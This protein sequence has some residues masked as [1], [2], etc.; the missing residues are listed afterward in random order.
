MF[1]LETKDPQQVKTEEFKQQSRALVERGRGL[2]D[3]WKDKTE[4]N[5]F[6]DAGD[7][8]LENLKNDDLLC[9]L[10]EQAGIF[11]E[12][13]TYMD[14]DG[15]RQIDLEVLS[16]IRKLVVPVLADAFKYIPVPRIEESNEY[17]DYVIENLTICAYDIIPENIR[18]RLES[19]Y[20]FNTKE[21]ETEHAYTK[22]VLELK[23][24]RTEMKDIKFY[25]KRKTFPELEESGKVTLRVGGDGAN[26]KFIFLIEQKQGEQAK[27]KEGK[28]EFNIDAMDFDFDMS[29]LS[30]EVLVPMITSLYKR[31]ITHGIERAV[32][33]NL[34]DVINGVSNQL[35]TAM[36][37]FQPRFNM[38]LE[39]FRQRVKKGE[40]H[41][42][43][44]ER[45]KYQ[46]QMM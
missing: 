38:Q 10:R 40:I 44:Q 33:K 5:D 39:A 1:I 23:H 22:L 8:L 16:S 43:L 17:R 20:D 25:I 41:R 9:S 21:L 18:V 24:L 13:L 37:G 46:K 11:V 7:R 28:V 15:A 6:L 34:G 30:H 19:D 32:E 42:T 27:F 35:S 36:L 31:K 3:K 14:S 45:Q 26:L 2:I 29:T 12:D 4:L